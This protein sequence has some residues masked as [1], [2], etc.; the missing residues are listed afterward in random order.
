MGVAGG[1]VWVW[2]VEWEVGMEGRLGGIALED[3]GS[4]IPSF[5]MLMYWL[6]YVIRKCV[7][8]FV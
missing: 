6:A 2:G 1:E 7:H 8:D 4:K 3:V 5:C